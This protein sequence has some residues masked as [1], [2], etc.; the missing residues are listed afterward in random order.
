MELLGIDIGGSG[1][2]AAMVDTVTGEFVS[3]RFRLKTPQPSTPDGV[4]R[5]VAAV[6]RE[7]AWEGPVGCGFPA[8]VRHGSAS[9]ATNLGA[10]WDGTRVA[11]LFAAATGCKFAVANDADVAGLA[12][13]RFG[14]GRGCRGVTFFATLG[15]GIGSAVFL[16]GALLPNTEFGHIEMNGKSAEKIASAKIREDQRLSWK[17][18]AGLLDRFLIRMSHLLA[19]DRIIIGGGVSKKHERFLPLLTVDTEVIPAELR[20]QAGIVGAALYAAELIDL[21]N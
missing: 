17:K 1:I 4:T 6:V 3:E 12:E 15:T 13:M 7:F 14:A 20:N 2:K 19:P 11:D 18:W 10:V 8:Q 21:R 5:T 16:D 9:C